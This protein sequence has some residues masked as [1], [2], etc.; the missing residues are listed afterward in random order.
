MNS[1]FKRLLACLLSLMMVVSL[2]PMSAV[3]ASAAEIDETNT[4]SESN[5]D[6]ISVVDGGTWGGIDWT[7][8][9]DGTLTIAPT[10]GEPV[11][12]NNG[13]IYEVGQWRE[14]VTY[15]PIAFG[16][17]PWAKYNSQTTKLVIEE[18]VT[19]IG[20]FAMRNMTN[21]QQDEL[22]IPSTVNYI[23]QEALKNLKIGKLTFAEGGTEEL[24]IGVQAFKGCTMVELSLP[25][26]RNLHIHLGFQRLCTA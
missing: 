14:T 11:P 5:N 16:T 18:G 15:N 13:K 12:A 21:I 9:S 1:K 23:G 25:E 26:D 24:C 3:T 8:T 20:S 7:L 10:K 6:E 19:S 22:V 2:F 17:Q 4:V